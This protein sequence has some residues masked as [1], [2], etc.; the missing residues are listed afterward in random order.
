[1]GQKG[2]NVKEL[3]AAIKEIEKEEKLT[4]DFLKDAL[5]AGL[6]AAYKEHYEVDTDVK[7][8]FDDEQKIMKLYAKKSIVDKVINNTTEITLEDAIE[9]YKEQKQTKTKINKLKIGDEIDVE[10]NPMD[11]GRIASQKGKQI[12]IQKLREAQKEQRFTEYT[13]KIGEVIT[14]L[15]QK[16]EGGIVVLDLGKLEGVMPLKEQV[17]TEKYFVNQKLR[18]YVKE[19]K[20]GIK[21]NIQVLVSRASEDFVKRLFEYE[22]PEIDEGLIEI[23]SVSRD[24]GSRSKVAVYSSNKNIDPVGSCVGQKGIR[25]QNI[26]NEL[27]GEKIDVI[28]WN[29]DA[30]KYIAE[31]LLPAKILAIDIDEEKKFAQVIVADSELSLSIGKAGQNVKLAAMLTGYRIDIKSESQFRKIIEEMS[32]EEQEV[33]E[34]DIENVNDDEWENLDINKVIK[35]DNKKAE[36]LVK[37]MNEEKADEV[38]TE[39]N[40]VSIEAEELEKEEI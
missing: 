31:A 9:E 38:E 7:V 10:I 30:D 26:V 18:V 39:G 24:P 8:V 16:A 17:Q 14:G 33:S 20:E 29:E 32:N 6:E 19:V 2:I 12:I 22:I 27:E 21:G 5:I 4:Q 1:M 35:E 25:I 3:L 36:K 13:N 40:T 23:K 11:F 37:E 15:V 28:E 34:E